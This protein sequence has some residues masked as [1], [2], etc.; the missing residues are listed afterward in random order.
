VSEQVFTTQVGL[1]VL[2]TVATPWEIHLTGDWHTQ[3]EGHR[4]SDRLAEFRG[5]LRDEIKKNRQV[6]VMHL[7]DEREIA[8]SSER[9]ALRATK[10]HKSTKDSLDKDAIRDTKRLAK[11]WLFAARHL[12]G[13]I[14]GN[15][16]WTF[17]AEHPE[18]KV[19][20]GESSTQYLCKLLGVPWL[21]FLTYYRLRFR[22]A[23]ST[24]RSH[25][26]IVACHGQ[27]GGKLVGTSLNKVDDMRRIFPDA[28]LICQGHDHQRGTWPVESLVIKDN[29][30]TGELKVHQRRQLLCRT[31]S[32]L[33]SYVPGEASYQ[34]GALYRPASLGIVTVEGRFK[35][36]DGSI[37]LDLHGRA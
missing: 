12:L 13:I 4:G 31:G 8:S 5:R 18:H 35:E 15:H 34:V 3:D 19:L 9:A 14:Q 20:A 26:D 27:G 17:L 30:K 21:G 1:W 36:T 11:D 25:C 22:T 6:R 37:D 16:H 2:P 33:K 24:F 23:N 10:L 7:G 32:F 29:H 28:D